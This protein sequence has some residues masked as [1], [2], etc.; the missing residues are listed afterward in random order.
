LVSLSLVIDA[1]QLDGI[2]VKSPANGIH[3]NGLQELDLGNSLIDSPVDVALVLDGLF[4]NL[5]EVNIAHWIGTTLGALFDEGGVMESWTLVNDLLLRGFCIART[6]PRVG[7]IIDYCS[8]HLCR[9]Q[10]CA[11]T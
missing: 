2:D 5:P 11:R 3:Y 10:L 1:T 4:P 7:A 9:G 8:N 6:R